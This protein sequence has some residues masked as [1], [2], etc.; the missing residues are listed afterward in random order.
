MT[1][2][3]KKVVKAKK[4]TKHNSGYSSLLLT[5]LLESPCGFSPNETIAKLV[6]LH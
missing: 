6:V 3:M 4:I 5:F 1:D 2:L